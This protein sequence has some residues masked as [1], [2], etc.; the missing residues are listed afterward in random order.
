LREA[1]NKEEAA[2]KMGF[3]LALLA[4]MAVP[5]AAKNA[6]PLHEGWRLQSACSLHA[7]GETISAAGFAVTD[8]QKVNVP[9]TVLAAQVANKLVPDPFYAMNLRSIPGTTY[10]AGKNFSNLPM[11]QDSPY[12][13]GWWYRTEFAVG[14]SAEKDRRTDS[15]IWIHFGGINYRGEVWVNGKRVADGK[16][17]AGAYR[18]YDFDVT[19][20]VKPG[21]GNVLA[22]ETFAPTEKD[23]GINWVDWSPCPPDKDMGLWGDVTL[24][25][26]GAVTLRSPMAV[27]H[28]EDES[29]KVADVTVYAELHNA[30]D[31][32]VKGVVS[33][34]VAGVKIEQTV[35]LAAHEDREVVF[36]PEKFAQLK[37]RDVTPWWP[38]QMGEPHLEQISMGF[39]VGGATSDEQSAEFGFR[40]VTSEL[41]ANGS[42]LFRVNGKPILIRGAGWSQDMLLRTDSHKLREQFKLVREMHLNTIRLEG[43]LETEEFFHLADEQGVLV[44]LGWCCCDHWERWNTWTAEDLT[45]AS[46][47]LKSQ[48]LR[49][50]HHA[51]L[52]VWL[53]GSD[54]PPPANVEKA[55]LDIEAATHWPNPILSSATGA[56]TVNAGQTGVKMS[57]P[58][59]YVAPSYWYVDKANGGG[60]G[61][62]TETSPGPAI[63][64]AASRAKFLSD[65]NAWPP[66]DAWSLHNG[67]GEFKTLNVFNEAMTAVYA[68][69]HSAA[70]YER[71][72]QT[73]AYDSERAMFEAYT[74]NKYSSTGVV[75]WMLN[76]AWPSMIWHL[77]DYYLD[78]DAGYFAVRKA[79][80]PLHIQYSYDDAA[81][82]VVNSTYAPVKGLHASVSVHGLKWN[83]LYQ[84]DMAVNLAADSVQRVFE[85]PE[86]LF[87]GSE[88]VF[89]VDLTLKD[90]V[91]R[92][93]S[94]NF[95]WVPGTLTNFDWAR[96]DFTH[97]P[98]QRHEDLSAL[99]GLPAAQV[100]AAA[101]IEKSA[102][103]RVVKVH[104]TNSRS[105]LAFQLR[106]AVRTKDGGLIA[107]VYWSDNWV[108][109]AP[110][111]TTELTAQLPED[112]P[113]SLEVQVEGWNVAPVKLELGTVAITGKGGR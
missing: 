104:L 100:Q 69:P 22:V 2:M 12:A 74:K 9:S 24:G 48:M 71:V 13:C 108:E 38:K 5:A 68:E 95:Y 3:G 83:E 33:G 57:G 65:P 103:G 84:S 28:F 32:T 29:L 87:V 53:N 78:A 80:E 75:Q 56:G 67:G 86:K 58:Y 96:T 102:Q 62:N 37:M 52:L 21:A 27:T 18:T 63:P 19:D 54:N 90:V 110:G 98:A 61:F 41:T 101:V 39:K 99:T 20:Y 23:L 40:E 1:N 79:C 73:M 107:P 31:H 94:R 30:A 91:G 85:V 25:S 82:E 36:V 49:L 59:D 55:Y 45:I 46:E 43:K 93:V 8:W 44:M 50:R 60:F 64:S 72:A 51:S 88:R 15:R 76:N 105:A 16:T 113:E 77:Y 17:V 7:G 81:I 97:T 92:V 111:E 66:S 34:T 26:T 112:A 109:L 10:P 42:R 6:T 35:E 47:S 70:D 106:A 14:A 89:F 4:A 11:A